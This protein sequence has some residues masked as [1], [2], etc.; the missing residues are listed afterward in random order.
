[1]TLIVGNDEAIT[2]MARFDGLSDHAILRNDR[3][4]AHRSDSRRFASVG[5]EEGFSASE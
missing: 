2:S 3:T 4:V 1:M 5:G